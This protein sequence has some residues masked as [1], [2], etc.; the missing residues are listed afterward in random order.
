VRV[1]GLGVFI[2]TTAG[3]FHQLLRHYLGTTFIKER[4]DDEGLTMSCEFIFYVYGDRGLCLFS[5]QINL[6]SQYFGI[7]RRSI[8]KPKRCILAPMA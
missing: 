4:T 7:E 2:E 6:G 8:P 3:L 5:Y 1:F